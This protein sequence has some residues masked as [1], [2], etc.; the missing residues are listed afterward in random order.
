MST[1]LYDVPKDEEFGDEAWLPA[2]DLE[3]I[4]DRLIEKRPELAHL[5][6]FQTKFFWRRKGGESGGHLTLGKCAKVGGLAKAFAP[7]ATFAVWL[8]ADHCRE[9]KVTSYQV[10]AYVYHELLHTATDEKGRPVIVGH[11]FTGFHIEVREY[12]LYDEWLQAAGQTFQQLR[13]LEA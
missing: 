12:G 5:Y 3:K 4:A 9:R 10:E 6:D 7:D 2:I 11:D 8:A 1:T 13:M